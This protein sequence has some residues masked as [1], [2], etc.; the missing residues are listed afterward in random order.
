MIHDVIPC[1]LSHA[2]LVAIGLP[3]KTPC[4]FRGDMKANNHHTYYY[5]VYSTFAGGVKQLT[6]IKLVKLLLA[7]PICY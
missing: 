5:L 7:V 4:C 3:G 1:V 6:F 2:P